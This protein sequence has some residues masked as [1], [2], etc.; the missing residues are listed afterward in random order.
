MGTFP[1][2]LQGGFRA[3]CARA[4][5]CILLFA[6]KSNLRFFSSTAMLIM[7][8]SWKSG[9]WSTRPTDEPSSTPSGPDG[10]RSSVKVLETGTT[11]QPSNSSR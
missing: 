3:N 10:S 5:I 2:G 8:P 11:Q 9:T 4:Y 7:A 6:N 1:M